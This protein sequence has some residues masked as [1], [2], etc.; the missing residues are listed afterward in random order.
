MNPE[1]TAGLVQEVKK[2]NSYSSAGYHYSSSIILHLI[3][4]GSVVP[5][6]AELTDRVSLVNLPALVISVSM[7]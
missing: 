7:L 2:K 5:V 6:N 3:H 4:L 1:I